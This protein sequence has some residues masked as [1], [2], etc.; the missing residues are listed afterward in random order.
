MRVANPPG[1]A[2]DPRRAS[3]VPLLIAVGDPP[4]IGPLARWFRPASS[5]PNRPIRRTRLR[6]EALE[7]RTSP[8]TTPAGHEFQVNP[9][10]FEGHQV[11]PAIA[12]DAAG[13]Y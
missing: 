9:P 8:S 13:N 12:S 10:P 6:C 7:D 11:G 2:L 4:M 5:R 1:E 3:P